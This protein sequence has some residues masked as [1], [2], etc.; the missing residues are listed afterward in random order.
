MK[1]IPEHI[2]KE[3][4]DNG[5]ILFFRTGYICH[6]YLL[7]KFEEHVVLDGLK[8]N[9]NFEFLLSCLWLGPEN[10]PAADHMRT[11]CSFH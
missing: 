9:T 4:E 10:S 1:E 6:N 5:G 2:V 11:N 8:L 7:G 3:G